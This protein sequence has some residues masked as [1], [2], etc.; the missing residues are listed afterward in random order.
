MLPPL[1]AITAA[2][3]EFPLMRLRRAVVAL[4]LAIAVPVAAAPSRADAPLIGRVVDPD[5]QPVGK[6]RVIIYTA[7]VRI[8]TS[9]YCPSCYPDCRKTADSDAD[10][11]FSIR[12]LSDSLRFRVLVVAKGWEPRFVD[13]VDP[14]EGPVE[15][16]LTQRRAETTD[17][18]HS[19]RGQV[20]DPM[21]QPVV[22]ATLQPYGYSRG[23]SYMYFG[24]YGGTDPLGVTDGQGR[25]SIALGDTGVGWFIRVRARDMAPL[26]LSRQPASA[27]PITVRMRHGATVTGRLLRDGRPL[28]GVG[29]GLVQAERAAQFM[30]YGHDEIATDERGRFTF[31]NVTPG[32]DYFVHGKMTTLRDFGALDTIRIHVRGDE[33]LAEVGNLAVAPGRRVSGQVTMSDGTPL[34]PNTRLLLSLDNAFDAQNQVLDA[35]GRFDFHGV[36]RGRVRLHVMVRGYRF[37]PASTGYADAYGLAECSASGDRDVEGMALVLEP[38]GPR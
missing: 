9:P 23:P 35:G 8:G 36:P 4:S 30:A 38:D 1:D 18:R 24:P 34:P 6:A 28:P 20:L 21:S 13:K 31:S 33:S 26:L 19:L 10:G 17:P 2:F 37:A 25:F 12:A 7:S 15:F 5:G 22:G 27:T 16:R 3:P 29:V 14:L 32:E 11:R